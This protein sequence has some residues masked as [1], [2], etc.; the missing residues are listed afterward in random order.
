MRILISAIG[1]KRSAPES[2]LIDDYLKRMKPLGRALGIAGVSLVES[3]APKGLTGDALIK[4]EGELLLK[5]APAG[6]PIIALDER[7]DNLSSE[8]LASYLSDLRRQNVS[9]VAFLI[10]GADGHGPEIK[11]RAIKTISF[12]SATWPHMLVRVMLAEQLYRAMTILTGH[13]YH[14]A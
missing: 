3:E 5:A 7:G 9:D 6:A 10:G 13:P 8:S 1:K 14:R 2:A 12:G 4:R 11:D